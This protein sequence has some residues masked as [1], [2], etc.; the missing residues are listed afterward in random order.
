[1]PSASPD[2]VS[3]PH[4]PRDGAD[5][6]ITFR[7][8]RRRDLP[9]IAEMFFRAFPESVEHIVG[10]SKVPARGIADAFAILQDSEPAAMRVAAVGERV[11]GYIFA[12]HHLTG[13]W[14]VAILRGHLFRLAWRWITG[15]YGI[16]P[17]A[18]LR[19]VTNNLSAVRSARDAEVECDA[20]IYSVAVDPDY[21]G[22]GLG[23]RLTLEGLHYL[24]SVGADRVRL[25]VRPENLSAR[26]VYEKLGFRTHE[27]M[28]ED[29]QGKW[30][31]MF[32][33]LSSPDE[34]PA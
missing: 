7:Q 18:V 15:R 5:G 27:R 16:G 8:A 6:D 13:V 32:K 20:R 10:K 17:R 23:T 14:R 31:I 34:P 25:E 4:D 12:P 19:V 26:H 28:T 24:R 1:M 30:L 11:V 2:S 22:R 29:S 9:Q 33:D 21:Q 3:P